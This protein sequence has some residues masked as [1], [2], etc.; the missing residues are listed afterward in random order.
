MTFDVKEYQARYYQQNRERKL[1][2]QRERDA[3]KDPEAKRA[4]RRAYYAAN[5]DRILAQQ[6]E[7]SRKN[8]QQN[9]AAYADRGRR[10]RLKTYGLTEVDYQRM[11]A[12]QNGRCAICGTTQGRRKS[13][14]HP[15]YVDHDHKTGKVRGLL[16]QPCN[17]ALGMFEDDPERLR[18]AIAYLSS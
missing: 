14:D 18:K 17:S 16:C 10:T 4:Y 7:R 3:K 8:Y 2:A 12:T 9:K 5:R 15:L 11:L 6:R 13:D 1:A